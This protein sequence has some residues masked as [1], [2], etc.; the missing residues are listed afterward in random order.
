M[1]HAAEAAKIIRKELKAMGIK[2]RV[3][4]KTYSGGNSVDVDMIDQPRATVDAVK[5]MC[6]KFEYGHFNGQIDCYEYSNVR[7]DIPQVKYLFVRNEASAETKERLYQEMRNGWAGGEELP[8]TY[9]AGC[10]VRFQGDFV[11]ALVHRQF[12]QTEAA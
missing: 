7:N 6:A 2:A 10:N 5:K 4:S 3:T 12:C 9:D 8:A 11:C 1:T